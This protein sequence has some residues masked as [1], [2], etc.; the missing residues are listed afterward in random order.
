MDIDS[1]S[2]RLIT[3][4]L[5]ALAIALVA[6]VIY[7]NYKYLIK[8]LRNK[9]FKPSTKYVK[10]LGEI[11][12][13]P[14]ENVSFKLEVEEEIEVKI[15]ISDGENRDMDNNLCKVY[16]AGTHSVEL[17]VSTLQGGSHYLEICTHAQKIVRKLAKT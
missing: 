7:L 10:V 8:Y 13:E 6:F 9:S 14:E 17:D 3:S 5:Y 1:V 2:N 11:S 15:K 16:P 4:L 12:F